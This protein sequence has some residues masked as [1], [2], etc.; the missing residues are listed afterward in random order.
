MRYQA[1]HL[2]FLS[3]SCVSASRSPHFVFWRRLFCVGLFVASALALPRSSHAQLFRLL[4]TF[5]TTSADGANPYA[6]LIQANDGNLY[7]TT[8]AG[9]ANGDGTIFQIGTTG[10]PFTTLYSFSGTDGANP[11]SGLIQARDGNL[12]GTTSEGGAS[13]YGTIFRI[14]TGGML[15]TL[16]SFTGGADGG[17][18][19]AGLIQGKDGNLYGV[20][21]WHSGSN[22]HSNGTV[23]RITTGG[24][25]T[26][27]YTFSATD[28][29][30]A[31][32]DGVYPNGLMQDKAG[33]LYGTT[34]YGGVNGD[35]TVFRLTLGGKFTTLYSF[36]T[37]SG[38][39]ANA[40]GA[41]PYAAL[42]QAKS[43]YLY[44]TS[45]QGGLYGY[46]TIFRMTIGGKFTTLH[47]FADAVDG[48]NPY[49]ALIQATDGNLYGTTTEGGARHSYPPL[50]SAGT[51]FQ[52][53]TGGTLTTLY[54][55]A[56]LSGGWHPYAALIQGQDGNLYGTA[57]DHGEYG[58]GTLFS[59]DIAL[60]LVSLSPSIAN[61]A[62]P[63]FAVTLDG[64]GF[65]SDCTV[66]WSGT[67]LTTLYVSSTQLEAAVPASLIANVGTAYISIVN[68]NGET[69]NS[70]PFNVLRTTVK[71]SSAKLT[72]D[73]MGNYTARISLQNIGYLTA[74]DVS[75]TQATLGATSTSTTLPASVGS[76]AASKTGLI[77]LSFPSTAGSSGTT[78][79][80]TVT[81]VFPNGTFTGPDEAFSSSLK[82]K[83]P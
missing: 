74:S 15:T 30:G 33:N 76:I 34:E 22:P 4:Y 14:T 57:F 44:G 41:H 31:N 1:C 79:T 38:T 49:A 68:G 20:T 36:S 13:G 8:Y 10:A 17:Y 40:D 50:S 35:G 45:T 70:Q 80:L 6:G 16:Y 28:S 77:S 61:A 18:P 66:N 39:N 75:I 65:T 26:T 58:L 9:G 55:F 53:T 5:G 24:I 78:P 29:N 19:G 47:S 43:G 71:L 62:G 7:G 67:A 63:A 51:A 21:D 59:M 81:G 12:Y 25:I 3:R 52:I 83:L 56:S 72:K 64:G 73:S 82:V 27:L 69:S 32:S 42:I 48:A 54:S 2:L 46:G 11:N 23:F 60:I 37:L